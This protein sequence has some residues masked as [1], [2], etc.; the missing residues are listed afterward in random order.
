MN[1][2]FVTVPP[3]HKVVVIYPSTKLQ[4][5]HLESNFLVLDFGVDGDWLTLVS[6]F[7]ERLERTEIPP[8]VAILQGARLDRLRASGELRDFVSEWQ[9]L[10][11]RGWQ[12]VWILPLEA[13]GQVDAVELLSMAG[14]G[15]HGSAKDGACF[16]E[17]H[18]PDGTITIGMPGPSL[19]PARD[20]DTLIKDIADHQKEEDYSEFF[21]LLPSLRLFLPLTAP[22]PPDFPR[23]HKVQVPAES[24]INARTATV[25]GMECVLVFTSR[26]HPNLGPD[27]IEMEGH[28]V[29][30]MVLKVTSVDGLLVQSSGTGWVGLDKHQVSYMLSGKPN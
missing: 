6:G 19:S 15:V 7:D 5:N 26:E 8:T 30:Q 4:V 22:P 29:L 14:F 10:R 9:R 11:E 16:I 3:G 28:D 1:D 12:A 18:K 2:G 24:N 13:A 17:I 25:Q 27:Y 23:G 20:P 21:Q